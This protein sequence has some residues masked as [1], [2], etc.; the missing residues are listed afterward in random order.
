MTSTSYVDVEDPED[1]RS[2]GPDLE[3]SFALV[4]I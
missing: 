1:S 3:K 2:Q 4:A